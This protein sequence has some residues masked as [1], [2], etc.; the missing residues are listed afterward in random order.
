MHKFD[1]IIMEGMVNTEAMLKARRKVLLQKKTAGF[2]VVDE[3]ARAGRFLKRYQS[4]VQDW[5]Y[6]YY[7]TARKDPTVKS[8]GDGPALKGIYDGVEVRIQQKLPKLVLPQA[9]HI[10]LVLDSDV[11]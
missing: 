4:F 6:W 2:D 8:L 3:L 7:D 11:E 10:E 1:K 9:H 5:Q